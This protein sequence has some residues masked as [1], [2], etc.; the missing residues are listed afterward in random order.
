MAKKR[1]AFF[2]YCNTVKCSIVMT[3]TVESNGDF[4][5]K[6]KHLNVTILL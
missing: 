1:V 4:V 6:K 5:Y 3:I 2:F